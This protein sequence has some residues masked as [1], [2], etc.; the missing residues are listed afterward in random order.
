MKDSMWSQMSNR[1]L[2]KRLKSS[3]IFNSCQMSCCIAKPLVIAL[4]CLSAASGCTP[5]SD[6]ELADYR[7]RLAR[8]LSIELA[9]PSPLKTPLPEIRAVKPETLAEIRLDLLDM[10]ALDSCGVGSSQPSLGNLIAE[11]NSSL[12]KVMAHSTQLQYEI[13][14]LQ[15]LAACLQDPLIPEDLKSTLTDIYQ[16]KQQQL[17]TRLTNFL[18][19]DQ[20]L[21]QQLQG[22]QRPLDLQ[23]GQ[24]AETQQALQNL[25]ILK[26]SILHKDYLHASRIDINQQ[27]APLYQGQVLA[28]LQ[29]SLR[30]NLNQLKTLNSQLMAWKP[31]RCRQETKDILQQIMLQIFIGKVQQQLAH[32]D[33]IAQ[34]VLPLL[35]EI[36]AGTALAE[37][38]NVRFYQPWQQLHSELKT[39]IHWWQQQQTN[40]Q[41]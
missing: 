27:L 7:E 23:S 31:A 39:H 16:Q 24:A 40:C 32:Q 41:P 33:S 2:I 9:A 34:N 11:R 17:A 15:A 10:L 37:D 8:T 25:L 26:Q 1:S 29:H 30:S 28:D 19:L 21:R 18:M 4:L 35:K 5:N 6:S 20:T 36:Y 38:V 14:L 22:S 12:G 13:Q 3:W